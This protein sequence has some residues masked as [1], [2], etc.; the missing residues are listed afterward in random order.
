M[1]DA[2]RSKARQLAWG[3]SNEESPNYNP[4][5]RMNR[6]TSSR[7]I[8]DIEQNLRPPQ[9]HGSES[10][11]VSAAEFKRSEEAFDNPRRSNTEP[12]TTDI[13]QGGRLAPPRRYDN[14]ET[15]ELSSSGDVPFAASQSPAEGA[16]SG[17]GRSDSLTAGLNGSTRKPRSRFQKLFRRKKHNEETERATSSLSE[18]TGKRKKKFT[19]WGQLKV[20]L[21]GSWINV[22]LICAPVGIAIYNIPS[23]NRIAVFVVNFLAIIPLAGMLSYATEEIAL[24]VGETLGG[25]LNASFG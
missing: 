10:H 13:V 23:V 12:T 22:L 14:N 8:Y 4:F 18:K 1:P 3:D 2:V 21:F 9:T 20:T 5:R 17:T 6:T 7:Q 15:E 16:A 24:R 19:V 25:L 11:F